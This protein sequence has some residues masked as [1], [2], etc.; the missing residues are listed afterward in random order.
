[1]GQ[2]AEVEHQVTSPVS[3][4]ILS[5]IFDYALNKFDATVTRDQQA[6]GTPKFL[7]VIDACV[8]DHKPVDMCLPAF[9]FMSANKVYKVLGNL[10]DKA[11]DLA[12]E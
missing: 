5:I 6:A 9:P 8:N 7:D 3:S 4:Q 2:T 12:L 1:M 11:E 10:P